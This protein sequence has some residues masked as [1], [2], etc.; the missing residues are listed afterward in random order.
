M[1]SSSGS[2]E[3]APVART[4]GIAARPSTARLKKRH[5]VVHDPFG[6]QTA[7]GLHRPEHALADGLGVDGP[8]VGAEVVGVEGGIAQYPLRRQAIDQRLGLGDIV[9]LAGREDQAH[10]QA[11]VALAHVGPSCTS[12]SSNRC[13]AA[14]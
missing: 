11:G 14:L 9:A 7:G 8:D 12:A 1:C 5:A 3:T 10:R 4:P 6:E 13:A 2:F